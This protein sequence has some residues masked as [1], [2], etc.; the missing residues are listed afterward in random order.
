MLCMLYV[1]GT[2]QNVVRSTLYVKHIPTQK[3]FYHDNVLHIVGLHVYSYFFSI[4]YMYV[5]I[6]MLQYRVCTQQAQNWF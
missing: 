5:Y 1:R 2:P 4:Q 6:Y 3:Y